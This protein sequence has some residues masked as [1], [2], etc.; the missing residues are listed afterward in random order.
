MAE[1]E[2]TGTE[3]GGDSERLV[4]LLEARI[5]EFEK[6][7]QKANRTANQQFSAIE[8]RGK[9]AAT[10]L[11]QSMAAVGNSMMASF[12]N[13]GAL[14]AGAFSTRA[15]AA[16]S[17]QYVNLQN[18][19]KVTGIEGRA[20]ETTF[21]N[22]F[23][24]A[25]K[26]GT[27]LEA[28]VT[29]YSRASQAQGELNANTQD[30]MR[31][32]DGVSL[33]LRVAG[34]D[35]RQ[36][37]GALLQL[38][39]ALGSGVVR[40]EEFNSVNEGARPILSAVAAGLKDAGGSVATLK[41]LVNEGKVSSEAFFRA[42]LAGLPSLES[43]ASKAQGTVGQAVSRIQ[44][45]FVLLIGELD[46]TAGASSNA[47]QNLTSVARVIE[48]IP[49]YIQRAASGF[50]ELQG[51]LSK[52]GSHPFWEKLARQTGVTFTDDEAK[53]VG[54]TVIPQGKSNPRIPEF[55]ISSEG[56]APSANVNQISLADF[57]V[58]GKTKDGEAETDRRTD[59]VNKYIERLQQ[60]TRILEAEYQ[61]LGKS[62]AER[63]KAIELARIGEV[64]DGAQLKK[65]EEAVGAN[66]A[67][68]KKIEDV[69]R[70][71]EALKDAGY[72]TGQALTDALGD[73]LID[74]QKAS[75]VIRDLGRSFAR[76][77]L[78]AVLMGNGPFGGFTGG[79]LF[80][81][82]FG[83]FRES[84]GPVSPGKAYVVGEKRPELFVPDRAGSIIPSVPTANARPM[85]MIYSPTIT[86]TRD[87]A[88]YQSPATG[89][90]DS[91]AIGKALDNRMR[92]MFVEFIEREGR[93]GGMLW[94]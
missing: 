57:P 22:L 87:G 1:T 14:A 7:F 72:A 84:G 89:E 80:G 59:Q 41:N 56:R 94:S 48:G 61:T 33:A 46:K 53:A 73:V 9:Q 66:E 4:V 64:T 34:T 69:Q 2:T 51:W 17:Q 60:S 78:Q 54:L 31:F 15:I 13:L 62:N 20:L 5:K 43:A 11:E 39:Q 88:S 52:V 10:R 25:Q 32:T 81:Q 47:A 65:I 6:N 58:N 50:S 77:A 28:L 30:L 93:P 86:V 67:L 49:A 75:D 79:G 71:T 12:R 70:Q 55:G 8:R 29:L 26:N 90:G 3:G 23:Q 45:A 27:P 82:L 85:Q 74:G 44:N 83:G 21:A 37:S 19:L 24:I 63:A 35:A 18:A 91:A 40:A 38:G 16:A 76:M 36:A 92:T 68:R 42:F